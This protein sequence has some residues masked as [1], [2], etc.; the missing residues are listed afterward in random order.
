VLEESGGKGTGVVD[1]EAGNPPAGGGGHELRT[2]V[3]V[4]AFSGCALRGREGGV[5][6]RPLRLDG[7]D[8]E[9]EDE[10]IEVIGGIENPEDSLPVKHV[11]VRDED[12]PDVGPDARQGGDRVRKRLKDVSPGADPDGVGKAR[13]ACPFLARAKELLRGETSPVERGLEV[14]E[15]DG[16]EAAGR[17]AGRLRDAIARDL[18]VETDEDFAEIDEER[19]CH[20]LMAWAGIR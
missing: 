16:T 8:A 20:G 12:P 4:E 11:R 2:V 18:V 13:K 3:G 19:P 7:A 6:E 10:G 9:G 5:P 15:K 1:D 17:C 14:T